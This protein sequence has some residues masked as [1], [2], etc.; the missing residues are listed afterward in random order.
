MM[1]EVLAALDQN[2][3]LPMALR[4]MAC[5]LADRQ[6]PTYCQT[7]IKRTEPNISRSYVLAAWEA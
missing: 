5:K 2:T 7:A 6:M 3:L 4:R 1:I